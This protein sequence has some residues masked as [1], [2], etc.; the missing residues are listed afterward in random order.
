[1]RARDL[2]GPN[3]TKPIWELHEFNLHA[4]DSAISPDGRYLVAEG[5][6]GPSL[7]TR[8][9]IV[10]LFDALTGKTLAPIPTRLPVTAD[11]GWFRFDPIGTVLAH[12]HS[13]VPAS[14]TQ[15]LAVPVLTYLG[16]PPPFRQD[17]VQGSEGITCL[18]PGG[19]LWLIFHSH[20][21]KTIQSTRT[22]HEF[23]RE[24]PLLAIAADT[25]LYGTA[26]QFSHDG[27]IVAWGNI[28]G[29]VSVCDLVEVQRRLAQVE[30]GW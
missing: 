2:L 27:H 28:D 9:R 18:G 14:A 29:T 10:T 6:H 16:E 26:G 13:D 20:Q 19:K 11:G 21:G 7:E 22:V 24:T 30:L 3:S 25:A 17:P 5:L 4:F 23:G 12:H 15:V 1:V 8:E